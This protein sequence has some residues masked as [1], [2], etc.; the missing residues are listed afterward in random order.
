MNKIKKGFTLVELIVVITILAILWTI[1]FLSF[2]SYS[3]DTRNTVRI[4]DIKLIAKWLNIHHVKYDKYPI[5]DDNNSIEFSWSLLWNQWIFWE[6]SVSNIEWLNKVVKDP[7]L[8]IP[9]TYSILNNRQKFQIWWAIENTILWNNITQSSHAIWKWWLKAY[10]NWDYSQNVILSNDSIVSAPSIII[11]NKPNNNILIDWWIYKFVINW[12]KNIPENYYDIATWSDSWFNFPF[13]EVSSKKSIDSYTELNDY[14][15]NLSLSFRSVNNSL[16]NKRYNDLIYNSEFTWF[17][18][19]TL[20]SLK[21]I[22]VVFDDNLRT[23]IAENA[24]TTTFLDTFTDNNWGIWSHLSDSLWSWNWTKNEYTIFNNVLN[25]SSINSWI[26]YAVPEPS[27]PRSSANTTTKFK[28]I[29]FNW[30]YINYYVRYTDNDNYYKLLL[31]SNWYDIIKKISWSE[32]TMYSASETIN[33]NSD[34]E[35]SIHQSSIKL[36][37][38]WEQKENIVDDSLLNIWIVW[39]EI[40]NIWW[41]ID[42]YQLNYK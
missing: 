25:K 19:S 23:E 10:I 6:K 12:L 11:S 40:E 26:L 36:L 32:T 37:I 21:N 18:Y 38:N 2:G 4:S 39:L 24:P 35:F 33:D 15:Y 5:P 28:I 20:S 27:L 9:Y 22:G 1:W 13:W 3:S 42:D 14:I 17:K 31:K 29:D 7:L 8:N 34:I 41:Q 30:W 16:F